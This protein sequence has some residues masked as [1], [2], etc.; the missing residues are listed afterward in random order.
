MPSCARAEI[1][2]PDEVSVYHCWNRCVR[3]AFL[4]GED[5]FT[6]VNYDYRRDWIR[7]MQEHLAG[8]FAIEIGFRSEMSNH[9]HLVL[10]TRPDVARSWSAAEVVRRWLTVSKLAKSRD[11]QLRQPHPA[12]VALERAMPGRVEVLRKRLSDPSW[13]MATLCEYVARRSNREDGCPGR[14]WEDRY[15]CRELVDESAIL[16]CGIY[17]E[18]NPIRAGEAP[19]P[20]SARRTSAYDRIQSRQQ[21]QRESDRQEM[22]TSD[23]GQSPEKL[24]DPLP[25]GWLCE[26]TLDEQAA[27]DAPGM[28]QSATQRRASDKGLIPI[29]LDDYLQLLDASGRM[30]R[31]GKTGAI[32][33]H[34]APILQRL[35]I[36]QQVWP[37]LVTRFDELFG[38]VVG[39]ADRVAQRAAQAGRRWYRGITNCAA[40][41]G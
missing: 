8:L 7:D 16:V 41:F 20:E 40:A 14:F 33:D 29:S 22:E 36:R 25:D 11:G 5:P 32:P 12:R 30:V 2:R 4:C 28:L 23:A 24:S 31:S 26:L 6:G 27:V 18:L 39:A 38:Q 17:V 34:L 19:T 21:R 37:E 35:G 9:V 13:L 15:Q 1:V 10:R 3:R